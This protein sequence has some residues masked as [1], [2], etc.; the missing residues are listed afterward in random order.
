LRI[1]RPKT[2]L[3]LTLVALALVTLPL[4]YAVGNAVYKLNDLMD[5]SARTVVA[6]RDSTRTHERVSLALPNLRRQALL[7]LALAEG[8]AERAEALERFRSQSDSLT[9][10]GATQ[11]PRRS[12]SEP[13][14]AV[15]CA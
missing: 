3:S 10:S 1:P 12:T 9:E 13:C 6:S 14:R 7:Y 15:P 4:L 8:S 11:T 2:L 5:E